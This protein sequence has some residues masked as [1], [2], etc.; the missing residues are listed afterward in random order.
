MR[1]RVS[2][3]LLTL[4]AAHAAELPYFSVLSEDAG[5]WPEILSS[6]GLQR[7]PAG[8]AR[9]FVARAGAAASPEWPARASGSW[10]CDL[11]AFTPHLTSPTRGEGPDARKPGHTPRGRYG[12]VL[13][14]VELIR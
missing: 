8:L 7:K 2:A 6:V 14:E 12:L 5:A 3:L 9:V 10:A 11:R 13:Q 1:L 4:A